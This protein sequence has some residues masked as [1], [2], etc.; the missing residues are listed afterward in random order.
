[1]ASNISSTPHSENQ[2]YNGHNSIYPGTI[3]IGKNANYITAGNMI[4]NY[5]WGGGK[6]FNSKGK[7]YDFG[8]K[9]NDYMGQKGYGKEFWDRNGGER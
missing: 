6:G 4:G 7:G 9:S 8:G 3:P 2:A 1:M 5:G